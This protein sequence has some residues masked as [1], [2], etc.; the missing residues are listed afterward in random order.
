[1]YWLKIVE[2]RWI[3]KKE[4]KHYF[5]YDAKTP[6][7]LFLNYLLLLQFAPSTSGSLA[8]GK[9]E[10]PRFTL[11]FWVSIGFNFLQWDNSNIRKK[12]REK[13]LWRYYILLW[14]FAFK[15]FLLISEWQSRKKTYK[16]PVRES[17]PGPL[18]PK[19]RIMPLDQQA[20]L[21]FTLVFFTNNFYW[22]QNFHL[23]LQFPGQLQHVIKKKT[24][25]IQRN[26][27]RFRW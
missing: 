18:A 13:F 19:A 3:A 1:M 26:D 10:S 15:T 6:Y 16:G 12:K 22:Q 7:S 17:N 20:V 27:V 23:L 9:I 2:S 11:K 5:Q 4:W 8:G 25:Q 14:N 21:K 24:L